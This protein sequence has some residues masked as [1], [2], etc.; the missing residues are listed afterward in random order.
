MNDSEIN[1]LVVDDDSSVRKSIVMFLKMENFKVFSASSGNQAIDIVTNNKIH[2]ILSDIK[3]PEMDGMELL[4]NIRAANPD[5]PII[6]LMTG[7]SQYSKEELLDSGAQD[8]IH[9]PFDMEKISQ[10]IR[11]AV[12]QTS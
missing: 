4:K 7:Y 6:V 9:K 1:V 12:S 10:Q 2:F 11:D 5:I 3:M 8:M